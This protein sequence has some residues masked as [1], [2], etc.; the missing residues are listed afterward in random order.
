MLC[1]EEQNKESDW[2]ERHLQIII[3]NKI[4]IFKDAA[5]VRSVVVRMAAGMVD[6]G[7]RSYN[8]YMCRSNKVHFSVVGW[9]KDELQRHNSS[10]IFNCQLNVDIK[11]ENDK[12]GDYL[13]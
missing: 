7:D 9:L 13:R 2:Y 10:T 4:W 1:L 12:Q 3:L 8:H 11:R 5:C 6:R